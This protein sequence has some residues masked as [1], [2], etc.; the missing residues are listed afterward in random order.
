MLRFGRQS[1]FGTSREG[2]REKY[3]SNLLYFRAE[4]FTPLNSFRFNGA[5]TG[6]PY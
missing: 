1:G 2:R 5:N 3:E 6:L 4:E